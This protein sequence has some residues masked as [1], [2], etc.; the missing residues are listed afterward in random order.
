MC[1]G[2]SLLGNSFEM[3][4]ERLSDNDVDA[5]VRRERIHLLQVCLLAVEETLF[6]R[7]IFLLLQFSIVSNRDTEKVSISTRGSL[8]RFETRGLG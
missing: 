8:I 7:L 5:A 2:D 3:D 1:L 4:P 6:L